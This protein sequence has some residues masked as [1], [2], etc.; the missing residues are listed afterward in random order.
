MVPMTL[1]CLPSSGW[2]AASCTTN[3][4]LCHDTHTS[5]SCI[6]SALRV[7]RL[8]APPFFSCSEHSLPLHPCFRA[9]PSTT[10]MSCLQTRLCASEAC[11]LSG[12]RP[13]TTR[14]FAALQ[15]LLLIPFCVLSTGAF[16]RARPL[17]RATPTGFF[18]LSFVSSSRL[19]RARSRRCT[20]LS[21]ATRRPRESRHSLLQPW[22]I[23]SFLSP[24]SVCLLAQRGLSARTRCARR[25][26]PSPQR[27]C[28]A[29]LDCFEQWCIRCLRQQWSH[30]RKLPQDRTFFHCFFQVVV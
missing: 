6:L 8:P 4:L 11:L 18:P 3:S 19:F 24:H 14:S 21:S 15:A 25:S 22:T 23:S 20:A 16:E 27:L 17:T 30:G 5:T 10:V 12:Y 7:L 1:A 9:Q 13:T 2:V 28:E 26:R 29:L